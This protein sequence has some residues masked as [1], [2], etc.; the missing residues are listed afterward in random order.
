MEIDDLTQKVEEKK[1]LEMIVAASEK[2]LQAAGSELNY[3]K[4]TDDI[5]YI[6]GAKYACFNLYDEDSSR[7]TTV[8]F[9]AP[10]EIIKKISSLL[11]FNLIGKR[12]DHVPVRTGTTKSSIINHFSTLSELAGD[13]ISKPVIFL[14][15][16]TLDIGEVILVNIS[17]EN[18]MLGSFALIMP[19]KP[20]FKNDN[21]IKIYAHQVGLLIIQKRAEK[22]LLQR[23][24]DFT[25]MVE[26]ATD[27][28]V[29]FDTE[30]RYIYCNRAVEEQ[31]GIPVHAIIGKNSEETGFPLEQARFIITM[32][33]RAMKTGKVQKAEQWLPLSSG[34]KYFSTTITPERDVF[35]KIKS[36][37]AITRDITDYKQAEESLRDIA[38]RHNT[39]LKT[40]ASGF[41]L[42]DMQGRL[43]EVNDAYCRMSGYS[44]QEL[45]DMS[46]SDLEAA[47]TNNDT[48]NQIQKIMEHGEGRFESRHRRKDGSIYDV[49]ISIQYQAAEDGRLVGFLQDIT[50]RKKAE[51]E[52]LRLSFHDHL[53]G[54]YN[55]R[56][57]EEELKRLDTIRQLPLCFI[58]ADL[59]SLKIV[60]D[61]FGHNEGDKLLVEAAKI[62]KKAC[63]AD[64]ILARWG[65]DEFI[66]ILP[67][68]TIETAEEILERIK[69]VCSKTS[70][71]KIPLSLAIGVAAKTEKVQNVQLIIIDAESNMYKNK[72][73]EKE[74]LSSSILSALEQTLYEKSTETKEHTDRIRD[75]AI[76]LGR[77]AKLTSKHLDELSL[78]AT[79]HDIGKVAIPETILLKEGSLKEKEWEV[80]KRH[81][82]IGFNIARSSPQIA[83]IARYILSCHENWDGSGYPQ[84][85]KGEEIPMISRIV[86]ICDSYDVMTSKRSYKKVMS[87]DYAIKELKRCAGTQFDRVLVEKFIEIISK[88]SDKKISFLT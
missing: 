43:L 27:I 46:V 28:I 68:T 40:T 32:L 64:D 38:E 61:I 10:Q 86:F 80:I 56:F 81:P 54:L 71:Q 51:A 33:D 42:T 13:L 48:A 19:K 3:Q 72:L 23:E 63:R 52:I 88:N 21:Y 47:K 24:Q 73:I 39:I 2:F 8:V 29:R 36:L 87:K 45:L 41:W 30:M 77:K 7:F 65:G 22:A 70:S 75:L 82:E 4:I 17:K 83:H 44:M 49:E 84:G 9:S 34:Q 67:K 1:V 60:N 20:E 57:F 26:N 59:N 66:I 35:G 6:S 62:L 31:L 5:L 76:K 18:I 85:L 55:R 11:G 78:L 50:E 58:M 69:K 12:W 53:T 16:K 74:S 25:S 15:E 79:L 37:L 14:L